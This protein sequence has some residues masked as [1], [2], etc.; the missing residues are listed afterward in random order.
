[1]V[2]GGF[3]R[4]FEGFLIVYCGFYESLMKVFCGFLQVFC[5]GFWI[6]VAE[7]S[8]DFFGIKELSSGI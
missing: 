8:G 6:H 2:F 3:L 1:M 4:V 7:M 5:D